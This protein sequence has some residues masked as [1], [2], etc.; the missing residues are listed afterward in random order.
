MRPIR[1]GASLLHAIRNPALHQRL[2]FFAAKLTIVAIVAM[3]VNAT[4]PAASHAVP[5]VTVRSWIRAPADLRMTF[6]TCQ[7]SDMEVGSDPWTPAAAKTFLAARA[8]TALGV[9]GMV[10]WYA[11]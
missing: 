5:K 3:G 11:R 6:D 8:L 4:R 7:A 1:R 10:C 2:S 9:A